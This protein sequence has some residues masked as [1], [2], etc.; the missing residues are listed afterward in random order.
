MENRK[1]QFDIR[2]WLESKLDAVPATFPDYKMNCPFCGDTKTRLYIAVED[3]P[4]EEKGVGYCQNDCG[5]VHFYRLFRDME[6]LTDSEAM[7][8]LYSDDPEPMY[9]KSKDA[10]AK[11]LNPENKVEVFQDVPVVWPKDYHQLWGLTSAQWTS[12]IPRYMVGRKL[13]QTMCERYYLGYCGGYGDLGQAGRMVIPI[14]QYGKLVGY[15]GRAMH[16][17]IAPKYLFMKGI[18]AGEY[19]YNLDTISPQEDTVILVEGV[20]DV[21][22]MVRHGYPNTVASFGKHLTERGYKTLTQ[23]FKR[24]IIFWDMDAK[25]EI[26]N[27]AESLQGVIEVWVTAMAGKDPD[28]ASTQEVQEAVGKARPYAPEFHRLALIDQLAKKK[29]CKVSLD[30]SIG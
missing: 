17:A 8:Q 15:Q 12:L 7:E 18:S 29:K 14:Y 24:V 4:D 25:L 27:L 2:S 21:W 26:C 16:D 1:I 19:L 9:G 13:D 5:K 20:F 10:L 3:G 6:N 23:R 28:E 30:V 11:Y 22:G